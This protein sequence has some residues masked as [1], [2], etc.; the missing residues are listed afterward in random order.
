MS[1]P[2][3]NPDKINTIGIVVVGICGAVLV[4]VSIVALQAFY[5]NDTS[6]IQTMA[7]YGG[8]D[9]TFKSLR[10]AQITAINETKPNTLD[11]K[12]PKQ[13]FQIPI[14]HAMKLVVRD[15][16]ADPSNLVPAIGPAD[17]PTLDV[18]PV[19]PDGRLPRTMAAPAAD[20][21]A[22]SAAPA[23]GSADPGTTTSPSP[24][25]AGGTTVT[26][27][28]TGGTGGGG[29]TAPQPA[30]KLETPTPAGGKAPEPK[31]AIPTDQPAGAAK[32]GTGSA[33]AKGNGR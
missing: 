18:P 6:V 1:G 5:L 29:G 15:A 12:N 4:Y 17:K 24:P 33:A 11:P 31:G 19:G 21:A 27:T 16:K 3:R 26:P 28:P 7:D 32:P 13:T 10:S 23:A 9:S 2:K 20:P 22:G 30:P 25:P 8:Q 14:A